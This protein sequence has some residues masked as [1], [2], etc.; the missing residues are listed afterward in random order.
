M[1]HLADEEEKRVDCASDGRSLAAISCSMR[2]SSFYRGGASGAP[3]PSSWFEIRLF[4]VRITPCIADATPPHLTL[5]YLR[6]EIGVALEINGARVPASDPTSIFLR[7]DRVDR[8]ASEV[9]YVSTDSVRLSGAVDF[10]VRDGD[11]LL[12][13]GALERMDTPWGNGVV[14]NH[15]GPLATT[16]SSDQDPKTGWGMDCYSAASLASSAFVQPKVGAM[17]P[18]IEVYVAG[19]CSGFPLIL[20]QTVQHSPR[21][22]VSRQGRNGRRGDEAEMEEKMVRGL[23]SEE[24]GQLSWF[25]AGV[26]VGVGIGLGMCLGLG[27]GVGLLMHSYQATTRNFKRRFF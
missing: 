2:G 15:P 12:L 17:F 19:C 23:Y 27:L 26:R 3:S 25:N 16:L 5:S 11:D 14:H 6:R 4:Y 13:C 9:T 8:G 20:T 7:R 24:D 21:R 1:E 18:S 22:K 10:E